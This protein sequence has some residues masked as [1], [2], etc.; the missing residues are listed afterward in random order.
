MHIEQSTPFP[1]LQNT[2]SVHL[3]TDIALQAGTILS[4][5]GLKGV[6]RSDSALALGAVSQGNFGDSHFCEGSQTAAGRLSNETLSLRICDGQ[7]ILPGVEYRFSFEVRNPA[8]A[9]PS[10][11]VVI[12]SSDGSLP[13]VPMVKGAED[14]FG[15]AGASEPLMIHEPIF[16]LKTICQDSYDPGSPNVLTLSFQTSARAGPGTLV[17]VA[18]LRGAGSSAVVSLLQ[19]SR[20]NGGDALFCIGSQTAVASW[21]ADTHELILEVCQGKAI[22]SEES[23]TLAFAIENPSTTQASPAV[24][25]E[26]RDPSG[27]SI[28]PVLLNTPSSDLQGQENFDP[29]FVSA[30][31]VSKIISQSSAVGGGSNTIIVTLRSNTK[32]EASSRVSITGLVGLE[33]AESNLV[34]SPLPAQGNQGHS[35]FCLDGVPSRAAWIAAEHALVLNLCPQ[36][37]LSAHQDCVFTIRVV[38]PAAPQ[39]APSIS[40]SASGSSSI[41]RSLMTT[42]DKFRAPLL[43]LSDEQL[44]MCGEGVMSDWQECEDGNS[45]GGDGCSASCACEDFPCSFAVDSSVQLNSV[46]RNVLPRTRLRLQSGVYTGQAVCDMHLY[47]DGVVLTGSVDVVPTIRCTTPSQRALNVMGKDVTVSGIHFEGQNGAMGNE[48]SLVGTVDEGGCLLTTG[49][50]LTLQQVRFSG[51]RAGRG[52]AVSIRHASAS[53]EQVM[54]SGRLSNFLMTVLMSSLRC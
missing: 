49:D 28:A 19:V 47:A 21:S 46:M 12:F 54:I 1:L 17:T 48:S 7:Q 32:L 20:G 36:Q 39:A 23:Y 52:G 53:F 22:E 15:I 10:P 27:M 25:I 26:L 33:I 34:L 30:E 43:I 11:Q 3:K 6:G 50:R 37:Q 44:A 51:C 18:N 42:G 38:N 13:H 24:S 40:I 31:F 45:V 16:L 4:I 14:L 29:L 2:I 35:L 41:L 5:S 8:H 9:Q